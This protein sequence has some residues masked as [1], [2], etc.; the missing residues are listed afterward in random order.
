M[1]HDLEFPDL[2]FSRLHDAV[3]GVVVA[4]VAV[5]DIFLQEFARDVFSNALRARVG[6]LIE[7]RTSLDAAACAY[8]EVGGIAVAR[9]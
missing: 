5:A 8:C 2:V 4:R 7:A 6:A 9:P 1:S 3:D